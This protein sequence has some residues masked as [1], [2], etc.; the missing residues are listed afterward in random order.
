MRESDS[1]FCILLS[2]VVEHL[3]RCGGLVGG[4]C[5]SLIEVIE[6]F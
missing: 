4:S 1:V 3:D 5:F 2:E 6:S